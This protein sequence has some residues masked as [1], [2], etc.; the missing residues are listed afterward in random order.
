MKKK[1]VAL[2]PIRHDSKRVPGKNYRN[3]NN[4]KP[5]FFWILNTLDACKSISDVY[6]D[7]DSPIIKEQAPEVSKKIKIIDR[8]KYLCGEK[9]SMNEVLFHDSAIVES[10]LFLQTHVTNPLLKIDT[11]EKSISTFISSKGK[12]SLFSVTR[13]QTRFWDSEGKPLNPYPTKSYKNSGFT[14]YLR[15]KLEYLYIFK[16]INDANKKSFR[17]KTNDV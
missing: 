9:V 5:L 6:I 3:F 12:D 8:P 7:T 17:R 13:F 14:T 4:G 11:I 15:R 16:K 1:I 10:E 2:V